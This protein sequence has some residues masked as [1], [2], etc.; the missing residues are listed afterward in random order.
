MLVPQL[1]LGVHQA[2]E[3]I[4]LGMTVV[5]ARLSQSAKLC[6]VALFGLA[7]PCGGVV[8][9]IINASLRMSLDEASMA[10]PMATLNG[11]AAG[12]LTYT[13]LVDMLSPAR[14]PTGMGGETPRQL[15]L[16]KL[17]ASVVGIGLMAVLAA[18]A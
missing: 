9:M 1:A 4:A 14:S 16:P 13:A 17:I 12:T 6:C 7:L 18:W 11:V 3:G 2:L 5:D 8:S 15:L 10:L